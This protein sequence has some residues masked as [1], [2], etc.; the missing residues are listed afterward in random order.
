AK[1][2]RNEVLDKMLSQGYISRADRDQS[3]NQP[4]P[5]AATIQLPS[6]DSKAPYFTSWVQSQVVD[7]FGAAKA[8]SGGLKIHTTL[9]LDLQQAAQ[10][11]VSNHLSDPNGPGA[12]L[13][14]IDNQTGEVRAMIGGRP[15]KDYNQSPFNL[16]TQGQRQPGSAFKAFVLAAALR[17]GISPDSVWT[18]QRKIFPVPG[19]GGKEKFV[20]NNFEGDYVGSRSLAD[21]T[22]NSDNSV[23]AEVGIKV[24]TRRIA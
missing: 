17:E 10:Q 2:R 16:A 1:Q 5:T 15:G 9:D 4:L 21:A 19:S 24:G 23:F 22:A 14:V 3:A 7:R 11:A 18:S 12:S 13:V 6:V 8:F 20:V